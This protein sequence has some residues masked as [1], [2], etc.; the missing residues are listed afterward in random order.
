MASLGS[1]ESRRKR[2][3]RPG[4]RPRNRRCNGP[5]SLPG[6]LQACRMITLGAREPT[7]ARWSSG[8][9]AARNHRE[10]AGQG[11][12]AATGAAEVAEAD[13]AVV[14]GEA[15]GAKTEHQVIGLVP[16]GCICSESGYSLLFAGV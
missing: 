6:S 14:A 8:G 7:S 2:R 10:P 12:L 16:D 15:A 3:K 11:H 9:R 4:N 13:A 5:R 1:R